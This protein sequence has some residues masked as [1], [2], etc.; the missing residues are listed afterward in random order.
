MPENMI[1]PK[2][3]DDD[4]NDDDKMYTFKDY[5]NELTISEELERK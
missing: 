1:S 3:D 2:D 5:Q 4:S